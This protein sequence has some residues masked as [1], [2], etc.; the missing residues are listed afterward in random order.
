MD[1]YVPAENQNIL[2]E[3]VFGNPVFKQVL[4]YHYRIKQEYTFRILASEQIAQELKK[5]ISSDSSL[6]VLR[7][8]FVSDLQGASA[9]PLTRV[10]YGD[11][12]FVDIHSKKDLYQL[13]K[14]MAE[15]VRRQAQTPVAKHI[16]KRLSLPVSKIL[17]F[18]KIS[19][20]MITLIAILWT[21]IGAFCLLDP[22]YY[23]LGFL[24]FQIN[25]L[26]DG[27]DGEVARFN[28]QFSE[29][30]K[31]LDVY[32]DYITTIMIILF[33]SL[34]FYMLYQ[35][36]WGVITSLTGIGFLILTGIVSLITQ[37]MAGGSLND[38]EVVCHNRLKQ[39][40]GIVDWFF[41]VLLA[42]G[43][44]DFYILALC[45]LALMGGFVAIHIYLLVLCFSWLLLSLYTM[46]M[47]RQ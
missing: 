31:K 8:S 18:Q 34:G 16:N 44:R 26:L 23:M 28:L 15:A 24:C 39:P 27:S 45:V 40:K 29:F 9:I 10:F 5:R 13:R 41:A 37:K 1:F 36:S 30:G 11:D 38:L 17:A 7:I 46:M 22:K 35:E 6:Q 20:N 43:H 12:K 4:L 2:F 25:S 19:P 3:R 42:L 47:C 14:N 21:I 32:C 33:E